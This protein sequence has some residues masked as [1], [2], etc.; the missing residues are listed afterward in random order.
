[1]SSPLHI[2]ARAGRLPALAAV[3]FMAFGPQVL[4]A[5]TTNKK[6]KF[7][8]EYKLEFRPEKPFYSKDMSDARPILD[9]MIANKGP[10]DF[11]RDFGWKKFEADAKGATAWLKACRK[12]QFDFLMSDMRANNEDIDKR[13]QA[14]QKIH[15]GIERDYNE[16]KA[17]WDKVIAGDDVIEDLLLGF[18]AKY[19]GIQLNKIFETIAKAL[20]KRGIPG[21]TVTK[22]AGK[23]LGVIGAAVSVFQFF[24]A[25]DGYVE[26]QNL[27]TQLLEMLEATA[28]LK[29]LLKQYDDLLVSQDDLLADIDKAFLEHKC[30]K[31][32]GG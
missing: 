26:M 32:S 30:Q 24:S 5:Q 4:Q 3:F 22:G 12:M 1:M 20:T 11:L 25:Y 28:Y 15:D 16:K 2:L 17:R 8:I 18:L 14:I 10:D 19:T 7:G 6:G 13:A 31:C 9:Q 29:V 27:Y 21:G 23:A